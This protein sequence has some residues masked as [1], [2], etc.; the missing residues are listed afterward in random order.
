M[1]IS[2]RRVRVAGH[3]VR[4]A[5]RGGSYRGRDSVLPVICSSSADV[6]DNVPESR[7]WRGAASCGLVNLYSPIVTAAKEEGPEAGLRAFVEIA[8]GSAWERLDAETQARRLQ[9]LASCA[10]LVGPH[11]SALFDLIVTEQDVREL[12]APTLLFYGAKSIPFEARIADRFRALRP[13]LS[14]VTVEKA[15][16]NV[17]RDRAD[18]VNAA[19]LSFLAPQER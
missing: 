15:G 7:A 16:H 11:L 3:D 5:R 14:V 4:Q 12:C 18:I 1:S 9:A 19:V 6:P 13:D 10:P 8:A 2:E 17:H